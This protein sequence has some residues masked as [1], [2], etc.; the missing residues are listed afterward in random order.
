MSSPDDS[1][2]VIKASLSRQKRRSF[3]FFIVLAGILIVTA[4]AA[5]LYVALL[6]VTLRIAVGPPGSDDQKLV[7]ALT[8]TFTRERSAVRLSPIS[9]DGGA[10]SISLLA[11]SK[12]DLAVVRGDL[13]MPTDAESV[14][15]VRKN[16][17]V[18]WA[19]SGLPVK[20]SK[21]PPVPKIK[22]LE[23]LPGHRVGIIGRTQAN[24]TLFRVILTE[25][26]IAPGKV[27]VVQFGR[28]QLAEMARDP[29][30][31]AFIAVGPLDSKITTDAIAPLLAIEANPSF[32]RSMC[33]KRLLRNTRFTNLRRFPEV[34]LVRHPRDLAIK[35]R[36]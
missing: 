18:L 8:Q 22:S 30:I 24:V 20:G 2:E 16:V 36:R 35:L 23:D 33:R 9:T 11:A 27:E 31:A 19:P 6:P 34:L 5:A 12:T 7:Q 28:N 21:K 4:A 29:T 32:F 1:A 13:E 10:E 25:S 17:V 26:G 3:G 14:A 15:I